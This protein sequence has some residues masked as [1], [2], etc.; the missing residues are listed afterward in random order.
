[1]WPRCVPEQSSRAFMSSIIRWRNGLMATPVL[2]EVDDTSIFKT[3]H[4]ARERSTWP[5]GQECRF[6][7]HRTVR[8]ESG[9]S[10]SPASAEDRSG[11]AKRFTGL[12]ERPNANAPRTDEGGGGLSSQVPVKYSEAW[13]HQPRELSDNPI[14]NAFC[15]VAPSVLFN[16]LAILAAGVFLCASVFSSRTCSD[17]QARLLAFLAIA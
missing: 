9:V 6:P 3:G 13:A 15:R 2:D 5:L 12:T 16:L 11:T 7:C 10:I 8:G 1:M 17:V 14:L 4:D